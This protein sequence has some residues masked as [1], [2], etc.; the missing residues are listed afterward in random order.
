MTTLPIM[1]TRIEDEVD[2]ENIRDQVVNAIQSA[3]KLYGGKKFYFNQAVF[4]F[5]TVAAQ[6]L[7]TVAAAANIE[8]FTE[9]YSAYVT[10]GGVRYPFVQVS[11]DEVDAAQ[12]GAITGRPTNWAYWAQKIRPYPIPDAAYVCTISAHVKLAALTDDANPTNTN[13]WMTDGEILIRQAA[14]RMLYTDVIDNTEGA[15]KANAA[16]KEALEAL[17]DETQRRRGRARLRVD[18]ALV[19]AAPYSIQEG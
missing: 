1:V 5:S 6:G 12:T 8:S 9:V 4:T 13:A 7:Y 3:I 18:S 15:L 10:S 16:E 19:A 14:K 11:H 2:D 17:E